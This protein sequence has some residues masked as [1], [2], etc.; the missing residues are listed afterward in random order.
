ATSSRARSACRGPEMESLTHEDVET[1]RALR[2][3]LH[4]HPE[5][6]YQEQRTSD[7]IAATLSSWGIQVHRGLGRTGV[8]GIVQGES[9]ARSV[10]LLA[11]MDALQVTENN[12]F[13]HA[14][15]H[16]G[17]MHACGH[18]GHVAMLLGAAK[19]LSGRRDLPGTVYLIFQP[20]EEGGGGARAMIED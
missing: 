7:L 3:D 1:L 4:A 18:D 20:A 12:T 11:D 2:R 8:V 15:I 10:G 5:L 9:S 19:L 16:K 17:R 13:A 6:G 14:S